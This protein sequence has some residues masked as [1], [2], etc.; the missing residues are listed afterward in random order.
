MEQPK[1]T[2]FLLIAVAAGCASYPAPTQKM[3]DAESS[4]RGAK[5]LGADKVPQAQLHVTLAQEQVD[6][7]KKLMADGDNERAEW[8]LKRA[9]IDAELGLA[10]SKEEAAKVDAQK[11]I[12]DVKAVKE[13]LK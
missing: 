13:K 9:Q 6:K 2:I 8:L 11:S 4:I 10:L 12:D 7:A 1:N 5:E 3:V